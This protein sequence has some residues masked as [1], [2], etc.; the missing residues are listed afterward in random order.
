MALFV[1]P[2][3]H[4]I[5]LV[6]E[7]SRLLPATPSSALY[8]KHILMRTILSILYKVDVS[9]IATQKCYLGSTLVITAI[10]LI[11]MC[12]EVDLDIC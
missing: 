3:G 6:L 4:Q 7:H 8:S 5:K 2:Q 1:K 11:T 9:Y 12:V 10:L